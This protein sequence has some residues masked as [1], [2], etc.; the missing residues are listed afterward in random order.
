MFESFA[1]RSGAESDGA[2]VGSDVRL[3]DTTDR[4]YAAGGR[5]FHVVLLAAE[6]VS[7]SVP[8]HRVV[9]PSVVIGHRTTELH[10]A[11]HSLCYARIIV[12]VLRRADCKPQV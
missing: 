9:G 3:L 5:L 11:V 12:L 2:L 6:Q 8:G 7:V 4:Q 10:V 1:R